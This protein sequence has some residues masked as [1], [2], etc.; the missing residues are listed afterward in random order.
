MKSKPREQSKHV[1]EFP[2]YIMVNGKKIPMEQHIAAGG[3]WSRLDGSAVPEAYRA[4]WR[5]RHV[6][7][8]KRVEALRL[9]GWEIEERYASQLA[10]MTLM[11]LP[12]DG[13]RGARARDA[14]VE[15]QAQIAENSVKLEAQ[16]EKIAAATGG[17]VFVPEKELEKLEREG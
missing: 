12:E 16:A 15:R 10:G 11:R 14:W 9:Q 3:D 7:G 1:A 13:P 2:D 4:G 8:P 6:N 17:E 5:H